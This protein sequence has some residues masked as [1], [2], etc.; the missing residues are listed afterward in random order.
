V[1]LDNAGFET[2][3]IASKAGVIYGMKHHD[4]AREVKLICN[5]TLPFRVI[6]TPY[7]FLGVRSTRMHNA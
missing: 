6:L 7:Y 3:V 2:I 5:L 4:Q 1:A